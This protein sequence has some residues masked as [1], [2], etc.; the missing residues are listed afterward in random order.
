MKPVLI[1]A[2]LITLLSS[3]VSPSA[4]LYWAGG[5]NDIPDGTPLPIYPISLMD[6]TW[7]TNTLNW[8]TDTNGTTYVAWSNSGTD[9]EAILAWSITNGADG[10]NCTIMLATNMVL[11]RLTGDLTR[12]VQ[13]QVIHLTAVSPVSINL[14]G[15]NPVVHVSNDG[16]Y[17]HLSCEVNVRLAGTNGFTKTGN[18]HLD[19]RS[20]SS[21]LTGEVIQED[22]SIDVRDGGVLSGISRFELS[23]AVSGETEGLNVFVAAG[24]AQNQ[25]ADACVVDLNGGTFEYRG[26]RDSTTPSTETI[27]KIVVD[28]WARFD[29]TGA[30]GAGTQKGQLILSDALAGID[31][32]ANG[33]GTL[34]IGA[35]RGAA[36]ELNTDVV[37]QNGYPTEE[38]LPWMS[39]N[40][41]YA[42]KLTSTGVI[43]NVPMTDAPLN[44]STWTPGSDY[45]IF[46]GSTES[47]TNELPNLSIHSLGALLYNNE[48]LN[49][50]DGNALTVSSGYIGIGW[51]PGIGGWGADTLTIAGGYLTSGTSELY[52]HGAHNLGIVEVSSTITGAVDVVA[53]GNSGVIISGP[54][55]NT[56]AGTTYVS[57]HCYLRKPDNVVAVPGDVDIG[58][59]GVLRADQDEQITNSAAVMIRGILRL[60]DSDNQTFHN[61]VTIR[62]GTLEPR[63]GNVILDAPGTGLVFNGGIFSDSSTL[64]QTRLLTDVSY[65]AGAGEQALFGAAVDA[66]IYLAFGLD[67]TRTF[68]IADSVTLSAGVAEMVAALPFVEQ[69][70]YVAGLRKTGDGV[71]EMATDHSYTGTNT[72][73]AGTLL[74]NGPVSATGSGAVIVTNTGTLGGSGMVLGA[75]TVYSGGGI[76]PGASIGTLTV[77]NDVTMASGTTLA[78]DLAD[79]S[80]DR[81]VV[82]GDLVIAANV[83]PSLSGDYKPDDNTQ[84]TIA[85]V[86]GGG[87]IDLAGATADPGY[88]VRQ[89][90]NGVILFNPPSGTVW[91]VR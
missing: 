86:V 65:A 37:V 40:R 41:G 85:T 15:S 27:G 9:N 91:S 18:A 11:N 24:G 64:G 88:V 8:A 74:A 47:L 39:H 58:R 61:T 54:S 50:G 44:V 28:S 34:T 59:T 73:E 21:G 35:Y 16:R 72:I 53:G 20:D 12:C 23:S 5:T 14:N 66:V 82:H 36:L 83:S 77:S 1:L 51:D 63:S 75:V 48:T 89:V 79:G 32:G 43:T 45:R 69:S 52:L 90:G 31:R 87:S 81:L 6:G 4:T 49:I 25:L 46:P 84:W 7:D 3:T 76:A 19:V 2:C 29:P 78:V 17:D 62:G 56:Y 26:R 68:D 80:N 67:A 60:W 13:R 30:G 55:P 38:I 42:M 71:M 57:G 70:G 33:R 22:G 10:E